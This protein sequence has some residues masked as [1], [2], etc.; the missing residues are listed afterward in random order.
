MSVIFSGD[1]AIPINCNI[2]YTALIKLFDSKIGV[3]NLEGPIL[4]TDEVLKFKSD[5]K[6]NLY[7]HESNIKVLKDLNIEL[8]SIC[9]N[10][11]LDFSIPVEETKTKLKNNNIKYFGEQNF[12]VHTLYENNKRIDII[13]FVTCATHHDLNILNQKKILNYIIYLRKIAPE[14]LIIVYP[15]WGCELKFLPEP[16]DRTM[17]RN[18][19]D[20]GAD[21]IIG[22]HPHV[23]QRIEKYKGKYIIYS[24]GNFI[25]PQTNFSG[26]ILKYKTDNVLEQLLVEINDEE[27]IIHNVYFNNNSFELIE[28]RPIEK[29]EVYDKSTSYLFYC[30]EYIRST[31]FLHCLIRT[32][33]LNTYFSEIFYFSINKG[34]SFLRNTLIKLKIHNPY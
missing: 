18:S 8:V 4:Q 5:F 15:H 19:I 7:T 29:C 20:C 10:H 1:F 30:L 6:Y 12:D 31:S 16:A 23:V 21:I 27:I 34:I 24:I 2:N 32:R 26:K 13:T 22:H 17:A 28:S 3:A 9:N 11:I 14:S 33:Y 25:L